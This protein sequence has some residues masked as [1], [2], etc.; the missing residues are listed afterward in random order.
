MFANTYEVFAHL[1]IASLLANVLV[2]VVIEVSSIIM[3]IRVCN[4]HI[5]HDN[6]NDI[7]NVAGRGRGRG[8]IVVLLG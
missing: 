1:C 8:R 6:G 3:L 5:M 7:N 2:V 4:N